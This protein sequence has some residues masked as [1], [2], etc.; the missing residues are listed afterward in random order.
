MRPILASAER[1]GVSGSVALAALALPLLGVAVLPVLWLV[2][3]DVFRFL[4]AED[5]P[6][7]YTQFGAFVVGAIV[8]GLIAVQRWSTGHHGQATLFAMV[9]LGLV[10]ISGEEISWGQ[11]I[12]GFQAPDALRRIN[13]QDEMT[14]HNITGVLLIFNIGMLLASLYSVVAEPI[15]RRLHVAERWPSAEVLFMPPLFLSAAFAVMAVFRVVRLTVIEGGFGVNRIG[16]WAELCFARALLS[17]L[18][19]ALRRL[20]VA[21]PAKRE[22]LVA[23]E[24]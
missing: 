23:A 6:I 14:F 22:E 24:R 10:V 4:T 12:F 9:A 20:R 7:E 19:L 2:N 3:E 8:S 11:R 18:S 21:E 1:W 5:G 17:F 15:G 16:E 13:E